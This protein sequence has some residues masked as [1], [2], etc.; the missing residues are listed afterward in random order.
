MTEGIFGFLMTLL[1]AF[2]QDPFKEINIIYKRVETWQFIILI[3][4][5]ILYWIFS[6]GINVYKIYCNVFYSPMTKS[7][8]TYFLNSVFILYH[9]I[10]GDAF[11]VEGKRNFLYFFANL[12]L[13][14]L[15]EFLGLIF[16]EI[17]IL[18][19]C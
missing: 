16:N 1:F 9:Y 7:L 2:F 5:L 8:A 15:I 3:F 11:V 18:N 10:D 13:V 17:F 14:I 6:A 12:I 19:F 4:L